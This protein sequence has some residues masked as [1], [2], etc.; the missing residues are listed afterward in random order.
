MINLSRASEQKFDSYNPWSMP[1]DF[2]V[3][4][5]APDNVKPLLHA[6]WKTQKAIHPIF[7]YFCGLYLLLMGKKYS[8]FKYFTS[9]IKTIFLHSCAIRDHCFQG[10]FDNA[11]NL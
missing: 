3:Y 10:Q 2:T 9:V 11:K 5:M 8:H 7:A 1:D 4:K 6:H